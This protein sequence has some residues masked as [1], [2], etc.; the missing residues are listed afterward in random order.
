MRSQRDGEPENRG[1][2]FRLL[3]GDIWNN[4]QVCS[5]REE[6]RTIT[7]G[8]EFPHLLGDRGWIYTFIPM[9][10]LALTK[11][12]EPNLGPLAGVRRLLNP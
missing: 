2:G 3:R 7:P 10:L 4:K 11:A 8:P 1:Q 12:W 6:N 5:Y 9:H